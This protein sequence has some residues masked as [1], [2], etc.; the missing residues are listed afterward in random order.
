M[1]ALLTSAPTSMGA[2]ETLVS[3]ALPPSNCPTASP[4]AGGLGISLDR[5]K[6]LLGNTGMFSFTDGTVDGQAVS[7]AT[8]TASGGST[9]A[10]VANGF[11]AQFFGDP[12]NLTRILVTSPYTTDQAT[13]DQG[14]A[15][16]TTL[17]KSDVAMSFCEP[18]S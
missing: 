14:L 8:L 17:F 6:S 13:I 3:T 9:F 18:R 15:A 16:T 11:S 5:T 10:A 4:N 12:C 1:P 2:L 7:T